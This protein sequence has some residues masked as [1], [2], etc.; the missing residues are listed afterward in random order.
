MGCGVFGETL[1]DRVPLPSAVSDGAQSKDVEMRFL[2]CRAR[3][4]HEDIWLLSFKDYDPGYF[5]LETH[6]F[7]P[8][9]NPF[10][11]KV[12]PM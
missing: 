8:L 12:S 4:A 10:G 11:P 2:N 1:V 9:E 3:S 5:D 6:V 7:D